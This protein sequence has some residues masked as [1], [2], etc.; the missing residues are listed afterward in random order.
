MPFCVTNTGIQRP[1]V[2]SD[3]CSYPGHE[4]P[5]GKQLMGFP[6]TEPIGSVHSFPVRGAVARSTPLVRLAR[7][8]ATP[9]LISNRTRVYL[10]TPNTPGQRAFSRCAAPFFLEIRQYSCEKMSCS[11][12][13]F[14]VAGHIWSFQIHP[15]KE[16][17]RIITRRAEDGYIFPA[18]PICGRKTWLRKQK[19]GCF[20]SIRPLL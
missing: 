6:E 9:Q 20:F 12:Q 19:A 10:K 4:C 8:C 7:R 15:R 1:F 16:V 3:L 18:Y 5:A 2:L 14:L 17:R 11:A 13:K